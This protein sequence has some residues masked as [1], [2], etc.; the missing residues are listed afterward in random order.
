MSSPP[1]PDRTVTALP[2]EVEVE[3]TRVR[4]TFAELSSLRPGAIL[5]LRIN[6]TEP[7]LLRVG[8]R[9]VARAELV[10]IENELGARILSFVPERAS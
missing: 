5:P 3:L 1:S 2:F 9:V 8:D 6:A 10:E 4:L 7:V